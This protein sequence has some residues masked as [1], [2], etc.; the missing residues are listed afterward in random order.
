[1]KLYQKSN[2]I[3]SSRPNNRVSDDYQFVNTNSIIEKITATGL[4][5][6]GTSWQKLRKNKSNRSGMQKHMMAFGKEGGEGIRLLVTNDHEGRNALKFDLGFFRAACANGIIV[7]KSIYSERIIH[8][9]KRLKIRDA[10]EQCMQHTVKLEDT[11]KKMMDIDTDEDACEALKISIARV[12]QHDV[13]WRSIKHQRLADTKNDLW[14]Q[15]NVFQEYAIRG[16]YEYYLNDEDN[17]RITKGG[18]FKIRKAP[19]TKSITHCTRIN[20]QMWEDVMELI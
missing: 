13:R 19:E 8:R 7:G 18:E 20:K 15:F 6:L 14:T 3:P 16:G 4:K 12:K 2:V 11:I 10:V 1:M 17:N 5:H 9:G